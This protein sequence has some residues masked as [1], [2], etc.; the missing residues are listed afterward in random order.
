M[1]I[2][3]NQIDKR[4]EGK[5]DGSEL[6][7]LKLLASKV[8]DLTPEGQQLELSGNLKQAYEKAKE[9]GFKGTIIEYIKKLSL[10]ELRQML[11]DGGKVIDFIKFAKMKNPKVVR[12]LD[13]ASQFTPERT[14]ASLT[15]DERD[16]V[17]MLLKMTLGKDKY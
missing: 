16:K 9:N 2:Q 12:K 11:G 1:S 6:E 4:L 13:L 15:E 14:L 5:S 3:L 8:D 7:R 10:E 17:N